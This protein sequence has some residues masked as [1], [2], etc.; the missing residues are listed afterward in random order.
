MLQMNLAMSLSLQ[1]MGLSENGVDLVFIVPS[2]L[3]DKYPTRQ[4]IH[5]VPKTP[6]E[7]QAAKASR[8]RHRR[9]AAEVPLREAEDFAPK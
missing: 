4:I 1:A 8:S 3:E 5:N 6:P 7:V 9:M 2:Y